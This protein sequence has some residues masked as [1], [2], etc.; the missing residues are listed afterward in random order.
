VFFPIR[1]ADDFVVLVTGTYEDA[2]KEKDALAQYLKGTAKLDLSTEKTYITAVEKGFEFLGHRV[3]TVW[4][5]R[6]GFSPR[7][8][9]PKQKVRDIRYR[10]KQL[11]TRTTTGWSLAKLLRKMNPILRG[12]V[13]SSLMWYRSSVRPVLNT[14]FLIDNT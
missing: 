3:R 13:M 14:A 1:Y 4:D 12:Y 8:E 2:R 10:I 6:F 5:D 11:T 7:I 9:I